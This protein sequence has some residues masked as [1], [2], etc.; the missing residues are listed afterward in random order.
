[1]YRTLGTILFAAILLLIGQETA[2]AQR[3][4]WGGMGAAWVMDDELSLTP[5]AAEPSD[6]GDEGL[7]RSVGISPDGPS[8][9]AYFQLRSRGEAKPA[10]LAALIE[11]LGDPAPLAAQKAC[12]ELAAIG[13]PAVPV[14]RQAVKDPDR[15][16]IAQL[17]QRCL[18]ALE[19]NPSQLSSA[20]IR[21]IAQYRPAGAAEALLQFAPQ[22]EEDS[23]LEEIRQAL[24]AVASPRGGWEREGRL[25]PA[26]LK[27]I[28]DD[29]PVRRA[30]AVDTLCQGGV[31]PSLLQQV[32]LHQLL[33]DP[34]PTV[35]LRTALAL[36]SGRDAKAVST[37]ITLLTELPLEQARQ[38]E[39][40]LTELAGDQ[41]P[42]TT[43]GNDSAARQKCR[44]A[45][46]TWW[47]ASEDDKRL[48]DEVRKRTVT[49]ALRQKCEELIKQLG[50]AD[51]TVREKA[52]A[53]VKAMGSLIVPLLRNA[54]RHADLEIRNRARDCLSV[55]ER[56]KN[57]P[58]SP[59]TPR[60]IALRKPAGAAETLL[61]Y[62][63]Y[64][65]EE[66]VLPEV[67][68]ALNA[69]AFK[70]GKP[71]PAVVCALSDAQ[72]ARRA[73]A[74][75][76]LCLG[77]DRAHLPMLRKMLN[78]P[79]PSVRLKVALALAGA[80][81]R[82]AVPTLLEL[83]GEL[84]STEAEPAEEYL[85]RLAGDHAPTNL[86]SGDDNTA[87]KKRQ[88]A[89]AAWWKANGTRVQLVERYPPA[90]AERYLG[91]VLLVLTNNGEVLEL[92]RDRKE[93]WKLTGLSNP[94]DAEV[95][96]N[97]RILVA[98][99][100]AQ[101]VTERNRKG[102][103]VWEKKTQGAFPIGVQRLRNGH[104]FIVCHD[105]LMEVDRAGHE[106]YSISRPHDVIAARRMRDG[107]IILVSTQR[108]CIRMDAAGKQLKS[109]P[110]QW[111]WQTGV[112]I[113]PNGHIVVPATWMNKVT[114]YDA[115]GKIVLDLNA[116]QPYAATRLKNGNL[117]MAPQQWPSELIETDS[118][119]KEVRKLNLPNFPHRI[120]TR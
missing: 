23:V 84:S 102:D 17:A 38:A 60:L 9:L 61:A 111:A 22:A 90:G 97:D 40:Y 64:A 78:D 79:E 105:K 24:A 5:A 71:E 48:L 66:T 43:L 15:Q 104:T 4:I 94:R 31:T 113:L 49:E 73:A 95:V 72:A 18:Q 25:D 36:S 51:F 107:Q 8:L 45:W 83:L 11:K 101:R 41:A 46:A 33:H 99:Q 75:E 110:L 76:A 27:A 54:T 77:G 35:R 44:D 118:T 20:A 53:E 119:G 98:E 26:L 108:Q 62:V 117:L 116:N 88:Q 114:E 19:Q 2:R 14:L 87:R 47:Q 74:A 85:Q 63:P 91:H 80:G 57:L 96:G 29:S 112:D 21:L 34:H 100:G 10:R 65:D 70:N 13:A 12:G 67:Q 32:P 30:L 56:D 109:F 115:D 68:L 39:E 89:W 3:V 82:D 50:D 55:M 81:Q 103:I 93:R 58:L 92:D 28:K 120:R 59:I 69:V 106:I 86:P 52:Q 16:Q 42:K 7:L 37:L 6:G 1:M